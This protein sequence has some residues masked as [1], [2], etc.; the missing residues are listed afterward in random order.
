MF[1]SQVV[2]EKL[3]VRIGPLKFYFSCHIM[4]S[5][6]V[7]KNN[8]GLYL[9]VTFLYTW[10]A[11]WGQEE[12]KAPDHRGMATSHC[13]FLSSIWMSLVI[14][15]H[16]MTT[17]SRGMPKIVAVGHEHP[18]A[19]AGW[20]SCPSWGHRAVPSKARPAAPREGFHVPGWWEGR[21]GCV[22][23]QEVRWGLLPLWAL[24]L[25]SPRGLIVYYC[26]LQ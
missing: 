6:R 10:A 5:L 13:L 2:P 7:V 22:V 15:H 19:G 24:Q 18:L 8:E 20:A 1:L 25:S 3:S 16:A 14:S 9:D 4:V 23:K 21:K 12:T 26:C 17:C 11:H